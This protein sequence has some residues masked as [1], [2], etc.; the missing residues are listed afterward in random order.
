MTE[1]SL[2]CD[3]S[4][5]LNIKQDILKN[6]NDEIKQDINLNQVKDK[7]SLIINK[8]KQTINEINEMRLNQKLELFFKLML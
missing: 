6:L 8:I 7:T 4:N 1:M 2:F 3:N 5:E